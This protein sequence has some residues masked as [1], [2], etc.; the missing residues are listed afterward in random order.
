[1]PGANRYSIP[2][3]TWHITHRCHK[4]EFLFK[5]MRDRKK[6]ISWLYEAKKR[7]GFDI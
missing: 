5:F 4:Q 7:F 2:G 1:M 6:W 3:Y